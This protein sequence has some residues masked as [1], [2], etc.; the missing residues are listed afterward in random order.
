MPR[1]LTEPLVGQ[2]IPATTCSTVDFPE[3]FV[4][5]IPKHSRLVGLEADAA[6]RLER[7]AFRAASDQGSERRL[8]AEQ[9]AEL[10]G[11]TQFVRDD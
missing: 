1:T 3:P 4:P 10:V 8:H 11:L 2:V 9:L 5:T 6:Q 7:A